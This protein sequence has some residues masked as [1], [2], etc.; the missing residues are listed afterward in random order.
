MLP[1]SKKYSSFVKNTPL[2]EEILPVKEKYVPSVKDSQ[3]EIATSIR[4]TP[5]W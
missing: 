4:N 2:Q 3:G 1:F 5:L